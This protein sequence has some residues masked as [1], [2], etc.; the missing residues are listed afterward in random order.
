MSWLVAGIRKHM[1]TIT[2]WEQDAEARC[3]ALITEALLVTPN[4][5]SVLQTLAS[6]RLSQ[7][8]LADARSALT[9]S[10]SI[11]R[12]LD[13]SD[14]EIP[15]FPTRVS[16]SRLLMEAEMEEEA[17]DVLERLALED[18]ESVEAAYLGGWCLNLLAEKKKKAASE[19]KDMSRAGEENQEIMVTL[20]ASRAWLLSCLK[21]YATLEYEDERLKEH[22]EELVRSQNDVLGPPPEEGKGDEDDEVEWDGIDDDDDDEDGDEE[23][24]GM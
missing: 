6:I 9:R 4:S 17:M 1:L 19:S 7:L 21:L 14:P 8:K 3:E 16:L 5:P 15:D 23:M 20:R 13:P 24:D 22:A 11:W 18:D 2:R 12:K 10:I